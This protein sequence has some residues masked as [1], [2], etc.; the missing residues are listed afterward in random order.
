VNAL[1]QSGYTPLLWAV[2]EGP[3]EA[4]EILLKHGADVSVTDLDGNT[5]MHI[6]ILEARERVVEMLLRRGVDWGRSQRNRRGLGI[7]RLR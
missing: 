7:W 6:A 1:D 3:D 4:V 5:P 2:R